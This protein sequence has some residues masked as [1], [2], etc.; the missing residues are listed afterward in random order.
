MKI[1]RLYLRES[2]G[3]KMIRNIRGKMMKNVSV[4]ISNEYIRYGE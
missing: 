4:R 1:N 3:G 2:D